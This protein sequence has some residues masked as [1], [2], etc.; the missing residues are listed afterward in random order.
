MNRHL[1]SSFAAAGFLLLAFGSSEPPE[2][3][4]SVSSSAS[5]AKSRDP[6]G[7]G[8]KYM[9]EAYQNAYSPC[10]DEA[11]RKGKTV[12]ELRCSEKANDYCMKAC[13]RNQ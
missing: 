10:V 7:G 9:D 5:C 11:A 4:S 13:A 6:M 8:N 3:T 12:D 2:N 1:L